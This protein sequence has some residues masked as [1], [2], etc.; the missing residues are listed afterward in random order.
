MAMPAATPALMERVEP[1]CAIDTVRAAAARASR[2]S[3]ADSPPK[4][5]RQFRGSSVRLSGTAPGRLSTAIRVEGPVAGEL[6][7]GCHAVVVV[8]VLVPVR[9]HHAPLVPAPPAHD[10]HRRRAERVRGPHHGPDVE[11]VREVLDRHME[12]MPAAVEVGDD[13]LAAPVAVGVDD[14]PPVAAGE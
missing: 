3:P 9:H 10:V 7:D 12:R 11:V 14:V 1:N 6:C 4:S 2:V 13:R 5:S 8:H